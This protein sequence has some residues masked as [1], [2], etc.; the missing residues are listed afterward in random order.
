[1]PFSREYS[2]GFKKMQIQGVPIWNYSSSSCISYV[3]PYYSSTN[4]LNHEQLFH[5]I[6]GETITIFNQLVFSAWDKLKGKNQSKPK[7]SQQFIKRR[8]IS[9]ASQSFFEESS[10]RFYIY[11]YQIIAWNFMKLSFC[12]ILELY[13]LQTKNNS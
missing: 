11:K 12:Q 3:L 6:D 1:M 4:K 2:T 8:Q 9:I 7:T 10:G 13:I 5:L